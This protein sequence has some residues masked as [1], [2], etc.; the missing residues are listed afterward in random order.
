MNPI[1]KNKKIILGITGSIAA[2]KMP[3]LIRELKRSGADVH[4]VMTP[5]STNFVT[6]LTIENLS[7]NPVSIEMFGPNQTS[8]AWHIDLAHKCDAMLIAP[9]SAK[10]LAHIAHGICDTALD[11]IAIALPKN[12]P[13][14]IAPAMDSSMWLHPATQK[15]VEI[16]KQNGAIIIPPEEGELSS[17]L[18]GPGRLPDHTILYQKTAEIIDDWINHGIKSKPKTKD[19]KAREIAEA[20]SKPSFPIEDAVAKDKWTAEYDLDRLKKK[21]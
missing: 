6:P 1:Y 5:S 3:F 9:C 14:I 7:R 15:N 17:G 18:I 11:T 20:F 13:L 16:C 21:F 2:Y 4:V 10:T 19:Q 12:I 8:G